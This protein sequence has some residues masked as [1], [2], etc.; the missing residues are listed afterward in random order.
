MRI[1]AYIMAAD[2]AWI[3]ASVSSYYDLVDEIVVAYDQD[4]L[5][6]SRTPLNVEGCLERLATCDPKGKMRYLP[7]R[8][9]RTEASPME[10]DTFQRQTALNI[11]GQGA[12][13]VIQ[14]D[15]DEVIADARTFFECL[16]EADSQ[17]FQAMDYPARWL[18]QRIGERRFFERCSRTWGPAASFPGPVAVKPGVCLRNAR[19]CAVPLY[20]VDFRKRNTDPC[21]GKNAPVHRAIPT[22]AGIVHYSWIRD[23][24]ELLKKTSSWGH[25]RDPWA[26][27]IAYW[28]WSGAHPLLATLA[29]PFMRFKRRVRPVTIAP[30]ANVPH[31]ITSRTESH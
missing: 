25:S 20:R 21:H 22:R 6:W 16:Q 28:K 24:A 13:W 3:E 23:E 27:E 9:A 26:R 18:Y 15:T 11:A 12:D 10:N 4:G 7:G 5:S 29:T 31:A 30:Q 19:Q 17:G 8:F 1:N 14:L 2:P